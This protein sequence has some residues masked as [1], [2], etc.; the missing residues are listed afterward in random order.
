MSVQV[1]DAV[2]WSAAGFALGWITCWF[3]LRAEYLEARRGGGRSMASRTEA[4]RAAIGVLIL[5][6]VLLTGIRYYQVTSCQTE[7]NKEVAE[8]LFQRAEAQRREGVAQIELLT[9]SLSDNEEAARQ[10]TREYIEAIAELERVRASSPI[11]VAPDCGEF[12]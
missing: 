11:P 5:V 8:S 1:Y 7:Y 4:A 6:L 3:I 10:E 9:A 12:R 2:V